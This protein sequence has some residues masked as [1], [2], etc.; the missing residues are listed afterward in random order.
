MG[1]NEKTSRKSPTAHQKISIA[2][3]ESLKSVTA[4]ARI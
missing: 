1:E 2:K 3:I 4:A